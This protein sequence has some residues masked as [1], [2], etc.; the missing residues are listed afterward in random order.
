[1]RWR[2]RREAEDLLLTFKSFAVKNKPTQQYFVKENY[3]HSLLSPNS[4]ASEL[5]FEERDFLAKR[6]WP[7]SLWSKNFWLKSFWLKSLWPKSL[8]PKSLWPK[9]LWPKSLW[10]KSLWPK[11]LLLKILTSQTEETDSKKE[12]LKIWVSRN[13]TLAPLTQFR[14]LKNKASGDQATKVFWRG[15]LLQNF[16]IRPSCS[17]E[18]MQLSSHF[19]FH[20]I[21]KAKNLLEFHK[22]FIDHCSKNQRWICLQKIA[23]GR[24]RC[25]SLRLLRMLFYGFFQ[26][27]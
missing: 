12:T 3:S 17:C 22:A 8:L 15:C 25:K 14:A 7:K 5:N 20:I 9:N 6:L 2:R 19:S 27:W 11:S 26:Q 4:S 18:S 10:P 23:M 16:I 24:K 13:A 21:F 1:M